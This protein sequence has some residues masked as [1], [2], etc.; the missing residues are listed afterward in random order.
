MIG[1][2]LIYIAYDLDMSI[3]SFQLKALG[4]EGMIRELIQYLHLA[5]NLFIYRS[6]SLG[7]PMYNTVLHYLVEAKEVSDLYII[8]L[9]FDT[10]FVK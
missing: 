10:Y 8:T 4:E 3:L 6:P 2:L 9:Y 5:E 1:I 7:T